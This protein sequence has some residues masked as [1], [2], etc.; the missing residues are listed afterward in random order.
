MLLSEPSAAVGFSLESTGVCFLSG[1]Q[2]CIV[3]SCLI[4][5]V[6]SEYF[7]HLPFCNI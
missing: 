2:C 6:Q 5:I 3:D 1:G 4:P 7:N